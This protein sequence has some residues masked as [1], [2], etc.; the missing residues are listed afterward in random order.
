MEQLAIT[1]A[2][3]Q[4]HVEGFPDAVKLVCLPGPKA[5]RFADLALHKWDL[6]ATLE[7]LSAINRVPEQAHQLRETLWESAI[8]HFIKCFGGSKS[9]FSLNAT[10]VYKGDTQALQAFAY[11]DSLRNK[12]LVHDDNSYTQCLV[13]AVLNKRGI[14]PKIAKI[15]ALSVVASVLGQ[16]N[17]QNLHLLATQ[18]RAWVVAQFDALADVLTREL[19]AKSYEELLA[20]EEITYTTPGAIDMHNKRPRL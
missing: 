12:H 3:G 2:D 20:M 8:V 5:Q 16:E 19:E 13:G 15:T 7:R 18:A 6:E 4:I 1:V 9:R 10:Q 14:S 11:F 17:Y